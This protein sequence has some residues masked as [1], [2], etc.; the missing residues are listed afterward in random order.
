MEY[1]QH[2]CVVS[3]DE[4][5]R[6]EVSRSFDSAGM[7]VQ[8]V[9]D[10]AGLL[11]GAFSQQVCLLIDADLAAEEI[12]TAAKAVSLWLSR[13]T[14]QGVIVAR[15]RRETGQ[16]ANNQL[17]DVLL[18][19]ADF[20]LD[21]P[22]GMDQLAF[23]LQNMMRKHRA[24]LSLTGGAAADKAPDDSRLWQFDPVAMV[25][26]PPV[27]ESFALSASEARLIAM[28]ITKD[29]EPVRRQD[30]IEL[31]GIKSPNIRRIDTTIYRLRHKIEQNTGYPSPFSTVHG[32][33]YRNE[34][35]S[36]TVPLSF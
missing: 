18:Q 21:K 6:E 22:V 11:G 19:R 32:V 33:G 25:L 16:A 15:A 17:C 8:W 36:A 7:T 34:G 31:F 28:L 5:L 24:R 12:E 26:I 27:G 9:P 29:P 35:L 14:M 3:P 10:W 1:P 20:L 30:L 23:A 2:L 13:R 4:T